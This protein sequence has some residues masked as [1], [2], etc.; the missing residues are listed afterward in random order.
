[1]HGMLLEVRVAVGDRVEHGQTLAI[2]E[3]MKMHYE[4]TA[5]ASGT[6]TAIIATAGIQVAADDL[7]IEIGVDE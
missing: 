2:L 1:M 5:D 4:I 6:V 3:A 7:L